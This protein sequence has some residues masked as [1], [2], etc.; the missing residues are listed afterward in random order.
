MYFTIVAFGNVGYGDMCPA[1]IR[2]DICFLFIIVNIMIL[3]FFVSPIGERLIKQKIGEVRGIEIMEEVEDHIIIICD[4]DRIGKVIVS[5]LKEMK[6]K[7]VI[8][9][10]NEVLTKI[11]FES[12]EYNVVLSDAKKKIF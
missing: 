9:E 8:V 6:S 10:L 12:T 3:D 2:W 1:S 4:Y 11:I 5:K 7:F